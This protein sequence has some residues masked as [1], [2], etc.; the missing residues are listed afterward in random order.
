M[1]EVDISSSQEGQIPKPKTKLIWKTF[2]ILL[3]ITALEF[4]IVGVMPANLLRVGILVIMTIAKAAYIVGEFMHLRY[5]VKFLI[6]AIVLPTILLVWLLVALIV[7]GGSIF[8][9]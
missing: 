8:V 6:W 1:A 3:A 5:E 7:E 9:S 4:L 2:F